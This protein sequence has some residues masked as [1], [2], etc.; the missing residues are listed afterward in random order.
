MPWVVRREGE[1]RGELVLAV[2]ADVFLMG[3]G[4]TDGAGTSS[5]LWRIAGR[6][7]GFL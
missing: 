4:A 1:Q 3:G 5:Y 2:L 6:T 7:D